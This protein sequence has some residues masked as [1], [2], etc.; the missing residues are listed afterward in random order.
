M[1]LMQKM[2]KEGYMYVLEGRKNSLLSSPSKGE[3]CF[4]VLTFYNKGDKNM[5][6]VNCPFVDPAWVEKE[7]H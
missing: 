3:S 5:V 6:L 7:K 1:L 4:T 2:N